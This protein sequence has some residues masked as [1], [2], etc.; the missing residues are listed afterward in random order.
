MVA[1]GII[2]LIFED[3][4]LADFS[5]SAGS[6]LQTKDNILSRALIG[7]QVSRHHFN[8][9]FTLP[10]VMTDGAYYPRHDY[11]SLYCLIIAGEAGTSSWQSDSW[12]GRSGRVT[13]HAFG[14][15]ASAQ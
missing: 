10:N 4:L 7:A 1:I 15:P 2:Y 11:H 14:S 5:G 9:S 12:L 8:I 13:S 6:K 3:R